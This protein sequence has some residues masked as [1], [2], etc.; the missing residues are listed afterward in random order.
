MTGD[1]WMQTGDYLRYWCEKG[2]V[3]SVIDCE[4]LVSLKRSEDYG[5]RI[6]YSI[7]TGNRVE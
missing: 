5:S 2:E 3:E 6:I 4:E 1:G 7:E